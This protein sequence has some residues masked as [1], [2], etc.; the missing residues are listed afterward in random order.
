MKKLRITRIAKIS[1][2]SLFLLFFTAVVFSKNK[3]PKP[4]L[5]KESFLKQRSY[6]Q[7]EIPREVRL[8]AIKNVES[9][10]QP[11]K[12]SNA[13]LEDAPLWKCIG[14]WDIAGRVRSLAINPKNDNIIYIAAAS[15]GIWKSTNKGVSWSALFDYEATTSFGAIAIDPNDTEILYA[16]S[17]ENALGAGVVYMGAGMY[18]TT[19]GGKKWNYIGLGK[20][21]AFSKVYVNPLNSSLV[22]AAAVEMES[23][24]Y[25]STDGG[26]SWNRKFFEPVTD[27][28][29][30]P[31]N[32]NEYFIGVS[33]RG[34]Y[35]TSD[36]G[37]TWEK[38]SNG[39]HD[40]IGRVS[41]QMCAS[42][43]DVLYSLMEISE[44]G[45]IYKSTNRG[46][47]WNAC[48]EGSDAFF[49]SQG[50]YNNFIMV[51]PENPKIAIAG[52]IDI[53]LT[54]DGG[55][56]WSNRSKSYTGGTMHMDQH[57]GAYNPF[58]LNEVFVGNDGGVYFSSDGGSNWVSRNT[59][60]AI[61]QFYALA[62]DESK[63]YR[64]FGGTQDN[65]TVGN[66]YTNEW[67]ILI[68][69]DGF[70]TIVDPDDPKIIFGEYYNGGLWKYNVETKSRTSITTGIA[71]NDDGSWN[72]PFLKS[73]ASNNVYYHARSSVYKSTNK[74]NSWSR[75]SPK[76][77][78]PI[79]ALE[80]SKKDNTKIWAGNE[81]GE[82]Y[83]SS[84][85]ENW[86]DIS[87]SG[88]PNRFITD[89]ESSSQNSLKI[90]LSI[91][92]Y[93]TS[94]VFKSTNNGE[95]FSD[96]A[97]NLP[98]IPVNA[99]AVHPEN[100]EIVFAATDIGIFYTPDGGSQW[101]K[102]GKGL[103]NVP[104][105]DLVFHTN[106]TLMPSIM[107]RCA[108]HGR[109]IWEAE[110][111]DNIVPEPQILSPAGGEFF[112]KGNVYRVSYYG[113][114][115]PVSVRLTT[116]NGL[117]WK[118][119]S[120]SN[121]STVFDWKVDELPTDFGRIEVSSLSNPQQTLISQHF[122]ILPRKN[123]AIIK[124]GGVPFNT[125]GIVYNG[126][127]SLWAVTNDKGMVY[128]IDADNYKIFSK[129]TILNN[130]ILTDI[131]YDPQKGKLYFANPHTYQIGGSIQVTDT[132]GNKEKNFQSPADYP[133]GLTFLDGKMISSDRDGS[134]K[135][136]II[137]P[138]NGNVETSI[139]NPFRETYGPRC[140]CSDNKFVYQVSTRY[141]ET[142]L[143]EALLIKMDKNDLSL[144]LDSVYLA[145]E[146][147]VISARGCEY[148]PR[149]G[150]FWITDLNG[151]IYKIA[152]FNEPLI[153]DEE[154]IIQNI[155]INIFP[156]PA[157][158]KIK[159]SISS[160]KRYNDVKFKVYNGLGEL[161]DIYFADNYVLGT[162]LTEIDLSKQ[163]EG[164]YFLKVI[165]GNGSEIVFKPFLVIR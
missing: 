20:I 90:Y 50:F 27:I 53:Y 18:K 120:E 19:N 132:L 75:I 142:T 35:Y 98:D 109:S 94:H 156:N 44:I 57:C 154:K 14:P 91:S 86:Q 146:D 123:G 143:Q 138:E 129:F 100:D 51:N 11:D 126:A 70:R 122:S 26:L 112:T 31:N 118:T 165:L 23:G 62:I 7:V 102:F 30:N 137:N 113:F 3:L 145:W 21:G 69:G 82:F 72:S 34:I 49:Y 71:A 119:I 64:S 81:I 135:L 162:D 54:T 139:V 87:G 45:R 78:A 77:F 97:A 107:L 155:K 65:G 151:N 39:L 33:G 76:L 58:N 130:I 103:P 108:T 127:G 32:P 89:I 59:G 56:T 43:P 147:G 63:A 16:G 48:F 79:S 85:G 61:T 148:D 22:V 10:M 115:L 40:G 96:I 41:V 5:R 46:K 73:P 12:Y 131:A 9:S 160:N 128:K 153:V 110:V 42:S 163:A 136:A 37:E 140:L 133:S 55:A 67:D 6:P 92:G 121:N 105:T 144:A 101:L 134:Q 68:K 38:R 150:S 141:A 161:V 36:R 164:A 2:I 93:G 88:I 17:G 159:V 80:I 4:I 99:L 157:K 28:S 25:I 125:Y 149:D 66:P 116:D 8:S 84:D 47:T 124:D 106:R 60:L 83:Y 117:N 95:T 13:I 74:G 15:G 52:G 158:D 104:V 29:F 114:S 152:A 1:I 24:F 111:P